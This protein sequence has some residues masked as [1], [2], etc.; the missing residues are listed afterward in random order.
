MTGGH[1]FSSAG[2]IWS[3]PEPKKKK[4]PS[5]TSEGAFPIMPDSK[6]QMHQ[7]RFAA[8]SP[9]ILPNTMHMPAERPL[10][11]IGYCT[12]KRPPCVAPAT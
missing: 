1:P 3:V 5:E 10:R 6:A 4:A 12:A 2:E 8:F 9:A 7:T 11:E